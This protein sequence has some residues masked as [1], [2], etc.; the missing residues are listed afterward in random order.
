MATVQTTLHVLRDDTLEDYH[1][2]SDGFGVDIVAVHGLNFKNK[3][4][5]AFDTWS[6]NDKIWLRDFLPSKLSVRTRVMLFEYNSSPAMGA[7][8]VNLVDHARNLLQHLSLKRQSEDCKKRP[9]VFVCHSLGGLVVKEALV[10]A[11]LDSTYH[12]ISSST[13]LLVFFATP[14]KGGKYAGFGDVLAK[15]V[16]FGSLIDLLEALKKDS[17]RV[18]RRSEQ[19]RHFFEHY[20]FVSFVEGLSYGKLGI[21]VDKISATLGHPGS[22]EKQVAM[23]AD[24]SSICKFDTENNVLCEMALN[25]ITA[26][27]ERALDQRKDAASPPAPPNGPPNLKVSELK[28]QDKEILQALYKASGDYD[29]QKS[30]IASRVEGTCTWV[31]SQP[32][33]RQWIS[34]EEPALLWITGNPGCGKSGIAKFLAQELSS[35]LPSGTVVCSFFFS[36]GYNKRMR[37]YQ[38]LCAVLHQ[39]FT[40]QPKHI[41]CAQEQYAAK[42]DLFTESLKGL[43]QILCDVSER[44]D[45]AGPRQ[46]IVCVIDALDECEKES[47]DRFLEELI[48]TFSP[49]GKP[50]KFCGSLKVVITSRPLPELRSITL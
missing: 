41:D 50:S 14:H 13:C 18:A 4:N 39:V 15:M 44:V 47:R 7:A 42:S 12:S 9:L 23:D 3:P 30:E 24:H 32:K 22:R 10:E 5:H 11:K 8:A 45:I 46:R 25:T 35:S 16:K 21:I 27:L 38:A 36:D 1:E 20:L 17:D 48:S 31:L 43:W 28:K 34:N 29:E 37:A 49:G 40:A 33:Y 2:T 19:F 26:E 6:L